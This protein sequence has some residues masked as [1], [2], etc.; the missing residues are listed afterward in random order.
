MMDLHL[1]TSLSCIVVIKENNG[2]IERVWSRCINM[3][4]LVE[5][6]FVF[7]GVIKHL[8]L[9]LS[10]NIL[11]LQ[12]YPTNILTSTHHACHNTLCILVT[13]FA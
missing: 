6:A 9:R 8:N 3:I 2:L 10:H 11:V 1:S 4:A 7:H 13:V 12:M 5:E